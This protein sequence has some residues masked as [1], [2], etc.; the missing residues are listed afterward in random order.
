MAIV[1]TVPTGR[2]LS[3][4]AGLLEWDSRWIPS[5]PARLKYSACLPAYGGTFPRGTIPAVFCFPWGHRRCCCPASTVE[6]L[7]QQF[8]LGHAIRS[9]ER[10]FAWPVNYSWLPFPEKKQTAFLVV[11]AAAKKQFKP[12][13]YRYRLL[14]HS[15]LPKQAA[16]RLILGFSLNPETWDELIYL[17]D[18]GIVRM[19]TERAR[20]SHS[21]WTAVT[22]KYLIHSI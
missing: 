16:S 15:C 12:Y 4:G 11:T 3:S 13:G 21:L 10:T 17:L 2:K 8:V 6:I 7:N 1:A 14:P 18:S 19:A 9:D 20:R 5:D 22:G